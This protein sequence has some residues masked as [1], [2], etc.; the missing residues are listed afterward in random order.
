MRPR[1]RRLQNRSLMKMVSQPFILWRRLTYV[2]TAF[3]NSARG[4]FALYQLISIINP[5]RQQCADESEGRTE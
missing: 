2:Y 4:S 1:M 3:D 5:L